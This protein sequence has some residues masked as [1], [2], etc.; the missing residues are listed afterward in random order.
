MQLGLLRLPGATLLCQG[1]AIGPNEILRAPTCATCANLS[2]H[3][4]HHAWWNDCVR[5]EE[6]FLVRK[7]LSVQATELVEP[8]V[9]GFPEQSCG[10]WWL[11]ETVTQRGP[12]WPHGI[13]PSACAR[14]P[15]PAAETTHV[16]DPPHAD[17]CRVA[18]VAGR[19]ST[20]RTRMQLSL[21][22]K[23]HAASLARTACAHADGHEKATLKNGRNSQNHALVYLVTELRA[24][25]HRE[26]A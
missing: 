18:G 21:H 12:L 5:R 22:A 20:H 26:Y 11:R 17:L 23:K 2:S 16:Q 6:Q 15:D 19:T 8:E 10:G 3:K 13:H 24:E 4:K 25:L 1:D 14:R 7:G 9:E